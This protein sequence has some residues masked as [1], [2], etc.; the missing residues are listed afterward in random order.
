MS[1]GGQCHAP[2]GSLEQRNAEPRFV[3]PSVRV[4]KADV[5]GKGH[6]RCIL[7][8]GG[9]GRL[10]AIAFRAAR[11]VNDFLPLA[12]RDMTRFEGQKRAWEEAFAWLTRFAERE[13]HTRVP[14]RHIEDGRKLA[15]Y[16]IQKESTL[17][18]VLRLRGGM[19][20][21]GLVFVYYRELV[22]G[23]KPLGF[24]LKMVPMVV[25][26]ET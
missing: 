9:K 23:T 16:S 19:Q 11:H 20:I 17:H 15:D 25:I 26:N 1:G 22:P 14:W 13:G 18:L 12:R 24:Q 21:Q 4:A 10:K 5:V 7:S 3:L 2:V 8:D 6:V